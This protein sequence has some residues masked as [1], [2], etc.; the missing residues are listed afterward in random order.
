MSEGDWVAFTELFTYNTN[1]IEGSELREKEVKSILEDDKWPPDAS[2]RDISEA[3]GVAEAV[4]YIRNTKEEL[5][6]FLIKKLHKIVFKN[7]KSF[8]GKLRPKGVEVVIRNALGDVVH[9]G[10]PANRIMGLLEELEEW[11]KKRKR[12][13]P[14]LLL[15]AVV[16]NQ[17][18]TIH[19][20][21]DGNGRVG[22]LLLSNIL[23]KHKL[24]PVN[25]SLSNRRE[26]YSA[27]QEYQKNRNVRP[28]I[29][30]MLKEYKKL[31]KDLGDYKKKKR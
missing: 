7:S 13:Y 26:Y 16:H 5:S 11:Y 14:P 1:A 19:P 22:R 27:L 8:A 25:I 6:I 21:Q 18:E 15:A 31:R 12:K 3:Y 20:F 28:T 10:A 17:F 29:D 23:L 4:K 24:P 9:M 2:K 30:L